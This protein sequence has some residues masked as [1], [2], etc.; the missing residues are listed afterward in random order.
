MDMS[1]SEF[2][3]TVP[4]IDPDTGEINREYSLTTVK[5]AFKSLRFWQYVGMMFGANV[6]GTIFSYEYKPYGLANDLEDSFLTWAGSFSSV[7]Q[8]IARFSIGFLY[9]YLGFR[10]LFFI[11]MGINVANSCVCYFAVAYPALY[12]ICIQLNY[13]VIGGIFAL[14]PAPAVKTFGG[15]VGV[16]VYALVLYSSVICSG[17][18]TLLVQ[19]LYDHIGL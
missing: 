1:S 2:V 14:F 12:F 4:N 6:F 7:T 8:V 5:A 19:L 16:R 17:F 3:D 10:L 15:D 13:F 18:D 11:I 9:D